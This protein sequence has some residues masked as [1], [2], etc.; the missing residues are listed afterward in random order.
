MM[1]NLKD[2]KPAT[3]GSRSF[4]PMRIFLIIVTVLMLL[5]VWYGKQ[6]VVAVIPEGNRSSFTFA[7]SR[8]DT[9]NISL[10]HSVEKTTWEEFF[11]V[12]DV[13]D[14]TMTHTRFES[15]GWGYPYSA[16][17]GR[18]SR[19][20]DGKFN[21]EMNR[22]YQD[23]VLRIS[24]QAMQHLIHHQED[25]DLVAMYGQGTAVNIKAQYRYEYWYENYFKFF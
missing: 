17:D 3:A 19:T 24:E 11:R 8:G 9:W 16:S 21:L 14:M 22:P 15:L 13:H 5:L 20:E 4:F 23:V 25:Y 1:P 7:T 6:M 12:N 2:R 18:F 10:T